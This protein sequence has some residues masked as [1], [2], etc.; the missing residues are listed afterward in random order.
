AWLLIASPLVELATSGERRSLAD[1]AMASAAA[2]VI[3]VG[4]LLRRHGAAQ[5]DYLVL[6]L[7]A[8]VTVSAAAN[9]RGVNAERHESQA[10]YGALL[11]EYRNLKRAAAGTAE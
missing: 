3:A 8:A 1:V 5:L 4:W 9:Y 11:S 10:R 7:A 2:A 6:G